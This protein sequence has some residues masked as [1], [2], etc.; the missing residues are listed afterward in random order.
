MNQETTSDALLRQ[1]R[2]SF[3]DSVIRA[4]SVS[5][6]NDEGKPRRLTMDDLADASGVARSTIAKYVGAKDDEAGAVI[7]PDLKTLCRLAHAFNVPPALLLMR[8]DDWKR[9]GQAALD[10]SD[11][12][13]DERV[14]QIAD[15]LIKVGTG[16]C[17][18][19]AI[20]SLKLAER[21]GTYKPIDRNNFVAS[22]DPASPTGS[23]LAEEAEA[24]NKRIKQGIWATSALPQ[25]GHEL[26][27]KNTVALLTLCVKLGASI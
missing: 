26:P 11:A 2:K 13:R 17:Q 19:R 14:Q 21:C 23:K 1:V 16:N 7:N 27:P 10:L 25:L 22:I 4:I 8:P 6:E 9:L 18:E 12:V 15:R 20:E 3:K 24:L 5:S